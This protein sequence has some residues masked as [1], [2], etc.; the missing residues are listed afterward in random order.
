VMTA[1]GFAVERRDMSD[2]RE[3]GTPARRETLIALKR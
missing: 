2:A 3:G 1:G